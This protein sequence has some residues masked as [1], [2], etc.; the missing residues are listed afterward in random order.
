MRRLAKWR[1]G[2]AGMLVL[3]AGLSARSGVIHEAFT[4]AQA[5]AFGHA[6]AFDSVGQ[7]IVRGDGKAWAGSGVYLGDGWVLTAGHVAENAESMSFTIAGQQRRAA[8]TY[9]H[10]EWGKGSLLRGND[11]A[12]VELNEEL[13]TVT[14]ATRLVRGR[15]LGRRAAAVGYGRTGEAATGYSALTS[16]AKR[17]GQNVVDGVLNNRVL[18]MDFDS[19]DDTDNALGT[20]RPQ[21]LEYLI[22]P[23]DSGGGLF[24]FHQQVW[25]LAGIHSFGWGV[26]DG[27][28]NA[29]YGD[30]S[31]HTRLRFYNRWIDRVIAGSGGVALRSGQSI[32]TPLFNARALST[33]VVPEPAAGGVA[34][35]MVGGLTLRRRGRQS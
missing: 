31:G 16:L 3:M 29:S 15:D 21:Q 28:P 35:A 19:G 25:K 6:A 4:Q 5:E 20:A 18:V 26:L 13:T 23:G 2:V 11:L 14:P 9:L 17:G 32:A 8:A 33:A 10:P 34:L 27:N 7:F 1:G 22:A 12:L 30:V 24:V